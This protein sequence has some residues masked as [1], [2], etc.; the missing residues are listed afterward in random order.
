MKESYADRPIITTHKAG[1]TQTLNNKP[2]N[3]RAITISLLAHIQMPA[4]VESNNV[5]IQSMSDLLRCKYKP[6]MAAGV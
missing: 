1:F 4:T 3:A 6:G 5:S 2:V